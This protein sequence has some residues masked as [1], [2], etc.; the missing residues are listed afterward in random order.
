MDVVADGASSRKWRPSRYEP[1]IHRSINVA[2]HQPRL[3][4]DALGDVQIPKSN[5]QPNTIPTFIKIV[6]DAG[7]TRSER[8][9]WIWIERTHPRHRDVDDRAEK[10]Q[11]EDSQGPA[12]HAL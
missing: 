5:N 11:H 2:G 8:W 3:L 6:I 9:R 10:Q 7:R 1:L 4:P 12:L